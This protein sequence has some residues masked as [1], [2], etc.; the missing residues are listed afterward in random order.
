MSPLSLFETA[1]KAL[2]KE[3]FDLAKQAGIFLE[4]DDA[5][6]IWLG[7][8]QHDECCKMRGWHVTYQK[9]KQIIASK[10]LAA[11][12]DQERLT[13]QHECADSKHSE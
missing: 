10:E 1:V 8:D 5:G 7:D 2:K 13:I 3:C 6:N 11:I 4:V 9:I 12:E